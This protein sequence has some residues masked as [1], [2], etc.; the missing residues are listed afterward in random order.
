M[1]RF[2][3]STRKP[4]CDFSKETDNLKA[5][6]LIQRTLL[7]KKEKLLW[8]KSHENAGTPNKYILTMRDLGNK[9]RRGRGRKIFPLISSVEPQPP[10]RLCPPLPF[11]CKT[12][13]L[14]PLTCLAAQLALYHL[15]FPKEREKDYPSKEQN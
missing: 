14:P 1:G 11:L 3:R 9:A 10:F 2:R 15:F 7:K 12:H 5:Q 6:V 4:V 8:N 13:C